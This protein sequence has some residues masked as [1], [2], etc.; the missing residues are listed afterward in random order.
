MK[1]KPMTKRFAALA[2]L[3]VY[4]LT[5]VFPIP[6]QAAAPPHVWADTYI[7]YEPDR[8]M[9]L[10][11]KEENRRIYPASMTKILT[12]I[13]AEEYIGLDEIIIVGHEIDNIPIDS[14]RAYHEVGE[15]IT[16]EN[17]LRGLIIPSGNETACIVAIVVA[18]EISGNP[19]ISYSEAE[20]L[21]CDLMN[22]RAKELGAL[23]TNFTNP[24]GYHSGSHYTT[25][26]DLALITA[27]AMKSETIM[28]LALEPNYVGPSAVTDDDSL[29]IVNHNWPSHN[30]LVMAG[31][32]GYQ[33]ATGLKTGY[34]NEAGECLAATATKEDANLIAIICN[35][36]VD[37]RWAD[38]QNLFEYGFSEFADRLIQEDGALLGTIEVSDPRLGDEHTLS[39]YAVGTYNVYL[40]EEQYGNIVCDVTI[41][42]ERIAPPVVNEETGETD[43]TPRI[44][45]P[46]TEGEV[47]GSVA[48]SLK[49]EILFTGE[50]I[51][52]RDVE[53]RSFNTDMDFYVA[54]LKAAA[55]TAKAIPYWIVGIMI[56]ILIIVLIVALVRRGRKRKNGG[57]YHF[58]SRRW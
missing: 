49:G 9:V 4:I 26:Y 27:E 55:F 45:T 53:E 48:Y 57:R 7:L 6:I 2:A 54:E 33:F 34:T 38:A 41:D 21:F 51:A 35:S 42:R 1:T 47:I 14:S 46:V 39:Y 24:H 52:G 16:G 43:N 36:P 18:R 44:L 11:A 10:L 31:A 56:P 15:A 8:G 28:R 50:I 5:A 25:A 13:L 19:D 20:K 23:D 12:A 40:N 37:M 22:T 17:I 32:E 58:N 29:K 3:C 30:K